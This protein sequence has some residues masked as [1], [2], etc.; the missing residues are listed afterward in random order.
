MTLQFH[1]LY[2]EQSEVDCGLYGVSTALKDVHSFVTYPC[3]FVS[4]FLRIWSGMKRISDIQ[5][6]NSS[7][8]LKASYIWP[9]PHSLIYI[10]PYWIIH[11]LHRN[12]RPKTKFWL[13]W[14]LNILL[15]PWHIL[16]F[17]KPYSPKIALTQD[18]SLKSPAAAAASPGSGG[19]LA[20]TVSTGRYEPCCTTNRS[21]AFC[22]MQCL[23][24]PSIIRLSQLLQNKCESCCPSSKWKCIKSLEPFCRWLNLLLP[25]LSYFG[26]GLL[27]TEK[28]LWPL[29]HL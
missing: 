13:M 22:S 18:M 9:W 28:N 5:S 25:Y 11:I 12:P 6:L 21:R 15:F 17:W 24:Q 16:F 10:L 1:I 26:D 19:P 7:Q 4:C 3:K 8:V 14:I 20:Q 23:L 27:L 2:F 29:S